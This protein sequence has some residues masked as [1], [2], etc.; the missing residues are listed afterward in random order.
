MLELAGAAAEGRLDL[1]SV[2]A[3]PDREALEHLQRLRGVGRWTAEYVLLRGMGRLHVFPGDDVGARNNLRD[4]LSLPEPLEYDGVGRALRR[5]RRFGGLLYF[6][7]LMRRLGE[8]GYVGSTPPSSLQ[9]SRT[10]LP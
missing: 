7:L 3:L 8:A 4:W 1:E 2:A 9:A 5:W 10:S 6:H